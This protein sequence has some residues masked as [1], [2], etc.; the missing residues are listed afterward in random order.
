MKSLQQEII[1][2]LGVASSISPETEVKKRVDFIKGYLTHTGSK[3]LVLGISGGQDSSLAGRLCQLA[4]EELR[5][6]TGEDYAFIAMRLPYGVQRDE[7]DAQRA[8]R[9]IRPDKSLVVNIKEAVDESVRSFLDGAGVGLSDYVKGNCKARERMISQYNVAGHYGFLVVGTD[10][11]AEAVTGF[12]TKYGDGGAD[13]VPLFGLSKR[14]GK[15][16]LKYLGA[17]PVVYEK[18]PTADLLDDNP[19]QADETELALTYEIIDDYLEGK[20]I[21]EEDATKLEQRFLA[22]RHKRT[23]PVSVLDTWWKD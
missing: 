4:V 17:E 13:L 8:L 6:V 16:L 5:Q 10:H 20:E 19:G 1:A 3:G 21:A 14:Q 7:E 18:V 23:I 22:T 15:E 2:E 12:F 11:A 9:F